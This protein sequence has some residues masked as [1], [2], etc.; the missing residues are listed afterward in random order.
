MKPRIFI[1]TVSGELKSA[2]QVVANELTFMDFEPVWQEVFPSNSG[3]LSSILRQTIDGCHAVVQIVGHD[4]GFESPDVEFGRVS[5]TQF[6]AH[7]ARSVGKPVHY[8]ILQPDIARDSRKVGYATDSTCEAPREKELLQQE[9]IKSIRNGKDRFHDVRNLDEVKIVILKMRDELSTSR[10][11]FKNWMLTITCLVVTIVVLQLFYLQNTARQ[12]SKVENLSRVFAE[13]MLASILTDSKLPIDEMRKRAIA[14]LPRF[15]P[16]LS[17]DEIEEIVNVGVKRFANHADTPLARARLKITA[18][19]YDG[20]LAEAQSQVAQV[21]ELELLAGAAAVAKF[22]S[23]SR[24]KYLK[25]AAESFLRAVALSVES[26]FH[27]WAE[28]AN[29]AASVLLQLDRNVEAE[30]LLRKIVAFQGEG[31]VEDA[32]IAT[33]ENNLAVMLADDKRWNEAEELARRCVATNERHYGHETLNTAMALNTLGH[34]LVLKNKIVEADATLQRALDLAQRAGTDDYRYAVIVHNMA[35]VRD[36]QNDYSNAEKLL[37]ECVAIA[38]RQKGPLSPYVALHLS[39]LARVLSDANRV[40]D[41]LLLIRRVIAI[42]EHIYGPESPEVAKGLNSLALNLEKE[43]RVTEA[44]RVLCRAVK[45]EEGTGTGRNHEI[46]TQLNNLVMTLVAQ[47]RLTA[48]EPLIRRAIKL[49]ES[50]ESSS[51]RPILYAN[52][53]QI[54]HRKSKLEEAEAF[55]RH[56]L[57]TTEATIG[58]DHPDTAVGLNNLGGILLEKYG[59]LVGE[60]FFRRA[61]LI[62][63]ASRGAMHPDSARDLGNL[64]GLLVSCE[65][66]DLAEPLSRR[67]LAIIHQSCHEHHPALATTLNNYAT[68]LEGMAHFAEAKALYRHALAILERTKSSDHPDIAVSLNN[69]SSILLKETR[70]RDAEVMVRRA[71]LILSRSYNRTGIR[72]PSLNGVASNYRFI[73]EKLNYPPPA[74]AKLLENAPL[75]PLQMQAVLP[76]VDRVLGKSARIDE[77]LVAMDLKTKNTDK[78]GISSLPLGVAVSPLIGKLLDSDMN[79]FVKYGY[80]ALNNKQFPQAHQLFNEAIELAPHTKEGPYLLGMLSSLAIDSHLEMGLLDRSHEELGDLLCGL[81]ADV[82][83]VPLLKGR[84]WC[85]MANCDWRLGKTELAIA[86][87]KSA[88]AYQREANNQPAL[89]KSEQLMQDIVS[90]KRPEITIQDETELLKAEAAYHCL[91]RLADCPITEPVGNIVHDMF[92]PAKPI[93]DVL[94]ALDSESRKAGHSDVWVLPL[95]KPI[96]PYLDS[97]INAF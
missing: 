69:L 25:I 21:R 63:E 42:K 8:L 93:T 88:I 28:A 49:E 3:D 30:Q 39:S 52:Y 40:S 37:R 76:E 16:E 13:R 86:E 95:T 51:L 2:R 68:T 27:E 57:I 67:A 26:D 55:A 65:A 91:R 33:A 1:S 87:L 92:G 71:F 35:E 61:L 78:S 73:L 81:T 4:Y 17:Q 10:R 15:V 31:G 75:D 58:T 43:G 36:R 32:V 62:D 14:E 85:Q 11:F 9:Y 47:H 90:G 41:S 38:E 20:V 80:Y 45:I 56:A 79:K 24:V 94:S 19:D 96:S 34:V 83:A 54:L 74:I 50:Q 23:E 12:Q 59:P 84:V 5:Y 7:Y 6:E 77:I 60:I 64:G 44:Q 72:H 89:R 53:S 70:Y 29:S 48:A 22:E 82:T 46:A 97:L 66:Y 18:A